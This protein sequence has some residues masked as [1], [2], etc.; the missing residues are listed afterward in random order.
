MDEEEYDAIFSFLE[1]G[2]LSYPSAWH[3]KDL[4]QA[5]VCAWTMRS[6]AAYT[7]AKRVKKE[8]KLNI[9]KFLEA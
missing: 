1:Y 3:H 6:I 9:F 5:Q 2:I 4:K 8:G 7:T